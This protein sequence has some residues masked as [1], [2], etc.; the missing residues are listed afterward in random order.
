V[1]KI[2]P[3]EI[4]TNQLITRI[5]VQTFAWFCPSSLYES[6]E[7]DLMEQFEE[8][9]KLVGEKR[10][11]RRFVWNV[12]KFFRSGIL[13]RNKLS[14]QLNKWD[15]LYHYF[16]I[17][18]RNTLKNKSYA[19]INIV[20]LAIGMTAFALIGLYVWN[21][22]SYDDFHVK[23]DRIFR[24]RHDR[25]NNGELNRLWVAGPMGIGS[26]LKDNFP[27]VKSFVRLNKGVKQYNAIAN[28]DIIFKEDR[29]LF[30]SEDFF[31]VF[32][33]ALIKGVDSLVLRN[34]FT[35]VVSETFAKRYFGEADPIGRTL[36]CNGKEEYEITGIFKDVPGNSH[37]K[38][39]ALFSFESLFKILGPE[40]TKD[41]LTN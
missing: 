25:F 6:I 21:E 2:T 23:K 10:A 36:K 32:S 13:L 37:L 29:V 7:G 12:L 38:F 26:D 22:R 35:M 30:A 33:F 39:D 1:M 20:G 8:D 9:V 31:K 4:I 19:F 28:G 27:E 14:V 17:L 15:M 40:E 3:E 5:I 41:L 16:K 18:F 11:K 24:V 34:P